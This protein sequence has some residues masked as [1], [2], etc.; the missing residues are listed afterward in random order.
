[1]D[2][3]QVLIG[4]LPGLIPTREFPCKVHHSNRLSPVLPTL[5][6]SVIPNRRINSV[7]ATDSVFILFI[8]LIAFTSIKIFLRVH[9]KSSI[10]T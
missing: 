6:D 2:N 10:E 1:M 7:I 5:N 4:L 9:G 3:L 8:K